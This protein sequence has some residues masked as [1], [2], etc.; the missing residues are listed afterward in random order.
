MVGSL[1]VGD[2]MGAYDE[3]ED[4]VGVNATS[5]HANVMV[6]TVAHTESGGV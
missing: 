3:C 4:R 6:L 5:V 2:V 1:L